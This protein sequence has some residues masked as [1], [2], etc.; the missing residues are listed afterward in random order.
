MSSA[1]IFTQ[2]AKHSIVFILT[3]NYI[4]DTVW[5]KGT[6]YYSRTMKAQISLRH[7]E[8]LLPIARVIKYYIYLK[9]LDRASANSID[10]D[11]K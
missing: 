7:S 1:E 4:F 5:W 9:Y 2:H 10:P 8:A 11:Q 6:L 3:T